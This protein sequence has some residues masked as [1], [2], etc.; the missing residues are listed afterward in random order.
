MI[1]YIE[2][3]GAFGITAQIGLKAL[4]LRQKKSLFFLTNNA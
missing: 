4:E 2:N 3:E 1:L